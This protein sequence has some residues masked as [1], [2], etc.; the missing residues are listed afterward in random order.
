M[1]EKRLKIVFLN[2]YQGKVNRGAETFVAALSKRLSR[3]YNVDVIS[4]INYRKILF[5]KYDVIIPTN[6]R[7][8]VFFI[9]IICWLTGAKMIV[10]GQSGPGADDKWNL[11]CMP[12]AFVGLTD[13]QKNWAKKFNPLVNVVKISNGVDLD[14]FSP[15]VK[16]TKVN[17]KHPIILSVGALEEGKRLDLIIKAVAKT[18]ASLL[19]IGKGKL[20][21]ELNQM[22]KELLGDRFQIMSFSFDEMPDVYTACD[23]FT[24]PTVPWESFGIVMAEAMASGL[25]VVATDD[26][27]RREIVG[28][29][30]LFVD[31]ENTDLYA[32][33]LQK[34]LNKK[35]GNLPRKQAEKFSWDEIAKKY[36]KLFEKLK[37]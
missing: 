18:E 35:W 30:G 15:K 7:E 12:D 21:S 4:K 37:L 33:N 29:A 22:G 16:P 8:Q 34:A 32:Q 17:L 3:N 9:R 10:S 31:P 23:L 28:G 6:G 26:P 25:P 11:L 5:G 2:K 14:K 20:E 24:Y 13:Y 27:I 1:G 19:L 36:E